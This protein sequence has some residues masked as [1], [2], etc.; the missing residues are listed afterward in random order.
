MIKKYKM[1]LYNK[2]G[3]TDQ[4]GGYTE[5]Q[6]CVKDICCDMQPYSADL[7]LKNY[8]YNIEVSKRLFMDK[9]SNVVI[10]SVLKY[11]STDYEVRKVIEWDNY[12]EVF[13]YELY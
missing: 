9:E 7:L 1:A 12:M 10:G 5:T 8:G 2:T 6:T 4:Y 3:I 11:N 13:A